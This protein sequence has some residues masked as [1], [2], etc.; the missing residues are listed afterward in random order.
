V[1]QAARPA[2]AA[3]GRYG[4]EGRPFN[5]RQGR[6]NLKKPAASC[7]E[8]ELR[9]KRYLTGEAALRTDGLFKRKEGRRDGEIGDV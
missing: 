2:L 9:P 5:R 1:A 3:K 8:G 7:R 6:G 4:G